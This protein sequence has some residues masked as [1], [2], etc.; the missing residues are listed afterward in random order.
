MDGVVHLQP[1]APHLVDAS[2]TALR[3]SAGFVGLEVAVVRVENNAYRTD[4]LTSDNHWW[5]GMTVSKTP[6][7]QLVDAAICDMPLNTLY[8]FVATPSRTRGHLTVVLSAHDT[9]REQFPFTVEAGATSVL[10]CS[11][12]KGMDGS[13]RITRHNQAIRSG[14]DN[15]STAM[16]RACRGVVTLPQQ[17]KAPKDIQTEA[18]KYWGR[19]LL[20][21]DYPAFFCAPYGGIEEHS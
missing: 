13:I 3:C 18:E 2:T 20:E 9:T 10:V 12:L 14:H 15:R 5:T 4:M 17:G 7:A 21:L 16:F 11:L 1:N 6:S 19:L 8:L